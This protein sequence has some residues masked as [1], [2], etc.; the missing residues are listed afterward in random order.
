MAKNKKIRINRN[1]VDEANKEQ[2][3]ARVENISC[4]TSKR[5]CDPVRRVT[6]LA[7]ATDIACP[8]LEPHSVQGRLVSQCANGQLMTPLISSEYNSLL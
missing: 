1:W 4:S 7:R 2:C 8:G 6:T 5:L 3:P